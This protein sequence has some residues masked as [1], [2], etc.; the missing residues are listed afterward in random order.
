MHQESGERNA[1]HVVE[2]AVLELEL[3]RDQQYERKLR[4]QCEHTQ[5]RV[6]TEGR[7]R[8]DHRVPGSGAPRVHRRRRRVAHNEIKSR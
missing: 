4:R 7:P 3:E 1:E 2:R 6:D 8:R 5:E